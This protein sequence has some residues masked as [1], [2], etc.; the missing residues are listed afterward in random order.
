LFVLWRPQLDSLDWRVIAL[1]LLSALMLF[2]FHWG[3]SRVL[4][5]ASIGGILLTSF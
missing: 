3:I 4:M 1:S 5:L 2:R